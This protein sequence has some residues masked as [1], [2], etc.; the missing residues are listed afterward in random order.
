MWLDRLIIH[1]IE[2]NERMMRSQGK[3]TSEALEI[4]ALIWLQV[5]RRSE[6]F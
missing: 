6:E 4:A 2:I 1:Q 3:N 5:D